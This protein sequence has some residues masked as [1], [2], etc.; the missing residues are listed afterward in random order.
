MLVDEFQDTDPVQW[1]VL[2]RAFTGHATMVL[3]GDPKQAIY[4]FRG[5][6]VTTY[7]QAAE[8]A[9]TRQTLATNWRS[10]SDLLD[11]L[12]GV[13][14]GAALGE[15]EIV[16]RDVE[17]QHQGSR[18]DG[19]G[20]PFRLR[21]VRKEAL[22]LSP[23]NLTVAQI[24]PHLY[25]DVARDIKRLL[26]SPDATFDGEPLRAARRRGDRLPQQ[27][28]AAGAAGARRR[29]A[30][31]PSSPAAAASSPPRRPPSGC[32]CSRRWSSRTGR[33]ACAAPH[34]PRSSAT[35][36]P[37]LDAGGDELTDRVAGTA[38]DWAELFASRGVAAV[39]EA[40]VTAGLTA[41]VLSRADGE[42][43]LTDLR[44]VGQSLHQVAT[45]ERL[46]LVA[47]LTWLRGQMA[48]DKVEVASERTRR[49]DSDA[50]AVQLVTIHGSKGLEY[51]VVY[52]PTL[53]DRFPQDPE[54][55]LFHSDA[56]D[57]AQRCIDVGAGGPQWGDHLARAA[58]EDDG[59][60]LRL[61]YVAMTR[62]RSQVVA[63]WAPAPRNAPRRRCSGCC[64]AAARRVRRARR[65]SR[66]PSEDDVWPGWL[67]GGTPAVRHRRRRCRSTWPTAGSPGAPAARRAPVHAVRGHLLAAYVVLLAQRGCRRRVPGRRRQR[68]GGAAE[69]GRAG[70]SLDR[71]DQPRGSLD[72]LDRP[73]GGLDRLDQPRGVSTASTTERRSRQAR[74]AERVSTGSTAERGSR[75]A[76][77]SREGVSTGST[78]EGV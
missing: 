28:P 78:A 48:D 61:L 19:A 43:L 35:T 55:P 32:G 53:W 62:A 47:L 36:P 30:C 39:L 2:D 51:P 46:G 18:L 21:V 25:D 59:E 14:R 11:A 8:T 37:E 27:R 68:A 6:D 33:R 10:D 44:H 38:R 41:R 49:L 22:G 73:R 20:A 75:Q 9:T 77:P 76:R 40:A 7:L 64:S 15:D 12:Q 16:V 54:V 45:D 71:L 42:R 3:I 5:G 31:P 4:A 56:D 13:L 57:G 65:G 1:Q 74:P 67:P 50:A 23:A 24:R 52:L 66:C 63:W 69:G 34:S 26:T 58:A 72:R 70:R 60:S 17:A 29:S